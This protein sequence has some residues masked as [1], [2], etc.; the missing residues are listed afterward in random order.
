M[1]DPRRN[2]KNALILFGGEGCEHEVSESSAQFILSR[3]DRSRYEPIAV[4]IGRDGLWLECESG[5][6][7]HPVRTEMGGGLMT[8]S[9]FV[10]IDVAFPVLHGRLGED[11]IVRG[12][13]RA[14]GIPS[15]GCRTCACAL[16]SDKAYAKLVA[17]HLGLKTAPWVLGD[18]EPSDS[19]IAE[20]RR[21]AELAFGY[22]MFI[23]PCNS[24][25]SLGISRATS[26]EDFRGAYLAAAELDKRVLV[27][28]AMDIALE[29]ECACLETKDKQ[30]FTK[31]G[32][33]DLSGGFYDY[34]S[35]YRG[36]GESPFAPITPATSEAVSEMARALF[37]AVSAEG[38]ARIDFFLTREREI[39]F[40]EINVMPGFTRT[41]LYPRLMER[42][43]FPPRELIG[44]LLEGAV[45]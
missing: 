8:E 24:G 27:E 4:M 42:C 7:C 41:S 6:V 16:T 9:G 18:R 33:I 2:T 15:V 43:G 11:G 13:L 17:E 44:A 19:Y 3:I 26:S 29:L 25:S 1:N 38:I 22:P 23:K 40:N 31:I 36:G 34:E 45:L 37:Y 12:A 14:S 21:R 10:P 39:I 28:A 20:V 30:L 5:G 35:K 32:S